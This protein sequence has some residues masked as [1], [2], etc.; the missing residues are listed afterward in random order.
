MASALLRDEDDQPFAPLA[1]VQ[2]RSWS[3]LWQLREHLVIRARTAAAKRGRSYRDFRVGA[4][5]LLS[6][7]R[8]E[9][10]RSIG[11]TDHVIYTGANWKMGKDD[12]NTCAE[13]E[14]VAQVRQ[15]EHLFP[16]RKIFA[17]A[18]AGEAQ[19]EPDRESGVF[20]P[21][22]HPCSH[23]RRLL[24]QVSGMKPDTIIMTVSRSSDTMEVMTFAELL[25]IH[26][27]KPS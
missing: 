9:Y 24:Q 18:I 10:L 14:I 27:V 3:A 12:R 25:S 1:L 17:L 11:R 23:C 22:L 20:T 2:H 8:P 4:A 21:T 13:Q 15:Q 6:S 19:D 7:A 5:A 16:P 26:A